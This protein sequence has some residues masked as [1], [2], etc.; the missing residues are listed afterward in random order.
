MAPGGMLFSSTE[1]SLIENSSDAERLKAV[2]KKVTEMMLLC[3]DHGHVTAFTCKKK[4]EISLK[5][6]ECEVLIETPKQGTSE[7]MLT[8]VYEERGVIGS[9]KRR[10]TLGTESEGARG[11]WAFSM[12][13]ATKWGQEGADGGGRAV[14]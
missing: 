10:L 13:L 12:M 1:V 5:N 11:D 2:D 4:D 3:L 8:L 9:S 14:S 6:G 7:Y